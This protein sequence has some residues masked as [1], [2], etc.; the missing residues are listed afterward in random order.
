MA[1]SGRIRHAISAATEVAR[2]LGAGTIEPVVLRDSNHV[3]IRLAPLRVVARVF[4]ISRNPSAV[5]DLARELAV[6]RHLAGRAAPVVPPTTELPAGPH[7]CGDAALS[8]WQFVEHRS[9]SEDDVTDAAIALRDIHD[10]LAD[11][12]TALPA[13]G[14]KGAEARALLA[15]RSALPALASADRIFL[16]TAHERIAA[17]LAA[18]PI[19][20][21]P[22]HGDAHLGN[23]L[24]TADGARWTDFESA[25]RGPREWDI[26]F[27]PSSDLSPF[28]PIDR[29]LFDGLSDLRSLCVA[30]WCFAKYDNPEKREAADYH[31]GWLKE[32]AA[33]AF[34]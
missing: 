16:L 33:R 25:C 27:L 5:A 1:E 23:V 17:R 21:H 3:S 30:V 20:S 31:L 12:P 6:A 8:L 14:S 32:R 4:E 19:P 29:E 9:A 24:V 18:R 2:R 7:F 15:D 13:F 11:F 34:R 22:I 10:A 26:G 28:G